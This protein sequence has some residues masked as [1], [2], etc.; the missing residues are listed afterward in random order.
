MNFE[1]IKTLFEVGD[2]VTL[3]PK[4][5]GAPEVTGTI[6]SKVHQESTVARVKVDGLTG[7]NVFVLDDFNI[8]KHAPIVADGLYQHVTYNVIYRKWNGVITNYSLMLENPMPSTMSVQE[9]SGVVAEG[10]IKR[11]VREA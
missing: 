3:K 4:R 1:I 6:Q 9:F 11:L 7:V 2:R 8:E 5:D 10:R